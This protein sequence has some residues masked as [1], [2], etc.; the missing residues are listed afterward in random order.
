MSVISGE[1]LRRLALESGM[2]TGVDPAH[3]NAASIDIVL[4]RRFLREAAPERPE[5][6][7][8]FVVDLDLRKGPNFTEIVLEDGQHLNLLPGEFVLAESANVFNLPDDVAAE[9]KLKSSHARSTLNHALAGWCDPGWHGSVLTMEFKNTSQFHV[10]RLRPGIPIGQMVF[11]QLSEPVP[12]DLSYANK[13]RYN[14]D[15]KVEAM[16]P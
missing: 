13:G 16:K 5:D 9:Y 8:A 10:L 11:F 14:N 2:V 7:E 12:A 6:E 3:I 15:K 1:R 4:G